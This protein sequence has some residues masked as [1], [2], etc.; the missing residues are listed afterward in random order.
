[1]AWTYTNNFSVVLGPCAQYCPSEVLEQK[2]GQKQE[3]QKNEIE[4]SCLHYSIHLDKLIILMWSD[5]KIG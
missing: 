1:M 4:L 3:T 5:V 2:M